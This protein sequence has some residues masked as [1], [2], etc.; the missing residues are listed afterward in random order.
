L[1]N[2][3]N[4][5]LIAFDSSVKSY[6]QIFFSNSRYLGVALLLTSFIN[7]YAGLGGVIAIIVANSTAYLIGLNRVAIKTG[8]YSFNSL[9]VGL[10][11]GLYYD[12]NLALVL[13]LI[14][15][16]MLTLF[17]VV[18]LDGWFAKYG[19]PFLSL[20]F[21]IGIWVVS[22][23][24]R[25]F[26]GLSISE[27]GVYL[28]NDIVLVGGSNVLELH[29]GVIDSALPDSLR[30]YFK[31][32]GAIFFQYNIYAG[33]IISIAILFTSRISFVLSLIGFYTAFFYYQII[34]ANITELSYSYIGFNYILSAIAIGGFFIIPSVYS[35]LWTLLLIPIIS[36]LITA[37][38]T[39]LGL[40]QL[41]AYSL[42]FNIV[43]ITFLYVLKLR[44]KNLLRP[45]LVTVQHFSPE[46]NLYSHLNYITRFQNKKNIQIALPFFGKWIV[47]QGHDGEITHKSE[48][49]DAWDF[50]IEEKNLQYKNEGLVVSDY[51]CYNKPILA[52][53]DGIVEYIVDGIDDNA[54]G[55]TNLVQNWGN[56]IV[57]KHADFLYS[58]VSH[59]K[60]FSF[61]VDVHKNVKKG[62]IIGYVGNSGRS[63][64]PHLHFQLQSTPS[65]G[66][67]TLNYPISYFLNTTKEIVKMQQSSVPK[68][69]EIV[70]NLDSDLSLQKSFGFIPGQTLKF[71]VSEN[72][73]F[74]ESKIEWTVDADFYGN[75][76]LFC[77]KSNSYAY[78]TK[79]DNE[80]IFTHFKGDKQSLLF[81]F[82]LAAY[83]V[84]FCYYDKL[85]VTD[86]MPININKRP[87]L[88][89]FQDF[90]APFY[91]FIS[92]EYR[93]EY[94][95]REMIFDDS[96]V[97]FN[98]QYSNKLFGHI[99]KQINFSFFVDR[100]GIKQWSISDNVSGE[101]KLSK[102]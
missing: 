15:S 36:L 4:D 76:Y 60:K 97:V 64:V 40:F 78:F 25:H 28:Y 94:I 99:A 51:F 3:K 57:I 80:L 81:Y 72:N 22:L 95:S 100:N 9:L 91:R 50:V 54:I 6:S 86:K 88:S 55:E 77:E 75:C 98:S 101:T 37:S 26:T 62:E 49:K 16:S 59:V 89:F 14:F 74:K 17:V 27:A 96:E 69:K 46:K 30:I 8:Y 38:S 82:Y 29:Q 24:S 56:S 70:S 58:Q 42:P 7:F 33:I 48:W 90:V 52:P 41:S 92:P 39:V 31:S 66:S 12:F 93:I 5:F 45:E 53:A 83:K 20:P 32:L 85:S 43:V 102:L 63:P 10:G 71:S 84:I 73:F 19:L 61:T 13:I 87:I 1:L 23:A 79:N 11:L 2:C 35:Y 44:E 67:K 68:E 65:V 34:G 21:L 18:F 47:D